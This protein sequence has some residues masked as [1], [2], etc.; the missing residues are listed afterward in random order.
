MTNSWDVA[1]AAGVSQSTVSR[2]LRGHGR[3]GPKTREAV[4]KAVE[5]LH[6]APDLSARALITGRSG[7]VAMVVPDVS[8]PMY[9]QLI[10]AVQQ[11]LQTVGYRMLLINARFGDTM[12]NISALRGGLVDGVL[13]ATTSLDVPLDR[14][15]PSTLPTVLLVREAPGGGYESFLADDAMGCELA[16]DHLVS[17]G[18]TRIAIISGPENLLWAGKRVRLFRAALRRRGVGLE[19][20]LVRHCQLEYGAASFVATD[21]LELEDAPTAIF[22]AGDVLALGAMQGVLRSG[23]KVPKDVSLVGFDDVTMAGWDMV[24]L[25]TIRQPLEPMAKGAVSALMAQIAGGGRPAKPRT[26]RFDVELIVRK[27]TAPPAGRR[28]AG[29][30]RS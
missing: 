1:R 9:P 19:K 12:A 11:E 18:H 6:Y 16:A 14:F 28:R 21:L 27:S 23:D 2:V 22:C 29:V 13:L 10:S 15:V 25:T 26:H 20:S 30:A 3:V 8:N 5:D 17:L 4:L 7:A 24:G